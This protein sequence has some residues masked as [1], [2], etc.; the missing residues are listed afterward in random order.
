MESGKAIKLLGENLIKLR[1]AHGLTKRE[2]AKCI[3]IGVASLRKLEQG[4]LP[5]RLCCDIFDRI[6]EQFGITAD[7]IFREI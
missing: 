4:L 1:I 3:G 5:P 2:M 7:R 6:Y